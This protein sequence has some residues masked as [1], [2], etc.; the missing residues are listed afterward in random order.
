MRDRAEI[1]QYLTLSTTDPMRLLIETM[2]DI[3]DLL[4]VGREGDGQVLTHMNGFTVLVQIREL[5]A[6][7]LGERRAGDALGQERPCGLLDKQ[8]AYVDDSLGYPR[9]MMNG[10]HVGAV[11]I[12]DGPDTDAGRAQAEQMVRNINAVWEQW[13]EYY[14][15]V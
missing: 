10:R 9:V 15:P 2:L 8:P 3:R 6:E 12:W 5:L 7:L 13:Y 4:A 1:L 11:Q 14:V